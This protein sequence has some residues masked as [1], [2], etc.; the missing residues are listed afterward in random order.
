MQLNS[1]L[2]HK[3]LIKVTCRRWT[4]LSST[5]RDNVRACFRTS[6]KEE[7]LLR[8]RLLWIYWNW[9]PPS[10]QLME[11]TSNHHDHRDQQFRV[12]EVPVPQHSP[13]QE[14]SAPHISPLSWGEQLETGDWKRVRVCQGW[15]CWNLSKWIYHRGALLKQMRCWDRR[16]HG[17]EVILTP[18]SAESSACTHAFVPLCATEEEQC[19]GI[20]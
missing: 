18:I 3:M 7:T 20:F 13:P 16:L 17:Q 14:T 19:S 1:T 15:S 10:Q 6:C 9:S 12:S 8:L 2:L 11:S 5:E 4:K